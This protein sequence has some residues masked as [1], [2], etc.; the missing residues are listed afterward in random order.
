MKKEK[1]SNQGIMKI[2]TSKGL[3]YFL[4][5]MIG[6]VGFQINYMI[7]SATETPLIEYDVRKASP[8]TVMGKD[9]GNKPLWRYECELT[10]ITHL[11]SFNNIRIQMVFPKGVDARIMDPDIDVIPPSS[12]WNTT[13]RSYNDRIVEYE[14]ER[15]Q[16]GC[17]YILSFSSDT[18]ELLPG[19]YFHAEN[20]VHLQ[21]RSIMTQ[22]VRKQSMINVLLLGLFLLLSVGYIVILYK[23]KEQDDGQ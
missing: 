5:L 10:N 13:A 6:A 4:T 14:I 11:T 12:L 15:L 16:P 20:S 3:P 21:E 7:K 9:P 18:S 19:V 17:Q 23:A 22:L 2:L 1:S 8:E